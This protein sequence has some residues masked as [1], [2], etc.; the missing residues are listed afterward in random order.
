MKEIFIE[1]IQELFKWNEKTNLICKNDYPI[2][3]ERH[4][5]NCIYLSEFIEQSESILDLGSGAGFPGLVLAHLGYNHITLCEKSRKKCLF[6][7][8]II[9]MKKFSTKLI[10][11]RVEF[12][13]DTFDVIIARAFAPLDK[14]L[15]LNLSC[16]RYILLKG[17]KCQEEIDKSLKIY[18]FSYKLFPH[19]YGT[20]LTLK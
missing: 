10:N 13:S 4:F 9:K 11:N 15:S 6:L 16:K 8:H 3:W 19:Q 18:K 14:I 12:I 1:Y 17:K 5:E 2:L 20:V 7:E